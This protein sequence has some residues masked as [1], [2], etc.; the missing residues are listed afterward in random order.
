LVLAGSGSY[1]KI[2]LLVRGTQERIA[3]EELSASSGEGTA[4]LTGEAV[5]ET[6]EQLGLRLSARMNQ[7]PLTAQ[8]QLVATLSIQADAKGTASNSLVDADLHIKEAHVQLPPS[9]RKDVQRLENP[10]DVV[11]LRN[12]KPVEK[13]KQAVGGAG[14][15]GGPPAREIRVRINAPRNLWVVSDDANVELGL[16]EGFRL[17]QQNDEPQVFGEVKLLRGRVEVFGRRFDLQRDSSIAFGGPPRTP[18]LDVTAQHENERENVKV[19]IRVT[20]TADDL[21]IKTS[22]DPALSETEIFTLLATGRRN[23]RPGTTSSGSTNPAVSVIGGFVA[24]QLKRGIEKV[25]PLDVLSIEPGE[26]GVAGTRVEAGTYVGDRLYLGIESRL[27]AQR[28]RNENQNQL[29]LEYQ[30]WKHWTFELKYGDA[31]Q[32]TGDLLWRKQY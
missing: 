32:G 17:I 2:H 5:R 30:L 1:E 16:A 10:P 9:A 12:G 27:G 29:D 31:R 22:S 7:F 15:A 21:Q 26:K 24:E 8:D 6:E 11:F 19:T 3:L 25:L 20:G 28:E 14:S 23:L 4:R 18:Q 13:P